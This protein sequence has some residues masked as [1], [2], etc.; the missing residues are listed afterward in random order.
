M[1]TNYTQKHTHTQTHTN[2]HPHTQLYT[3]GILEEARKEEGEGGGVCIFA[4]ISP[5]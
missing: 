5:Q 1:E 2:T 4:H 3:Q